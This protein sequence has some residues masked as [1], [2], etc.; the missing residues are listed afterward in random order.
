MSLW[1]QMPFLALVAL[2]DNKSWKRHLLSQA[3][4]CQLMGNYNEWLLEMRTV[5]RHKLYFIGFLRDGN[6]QVKNVYQATHWKSILS[7]KNSLKPVCFFFQPL[8]I[9]RLSSTTVMVN[10]TV[11]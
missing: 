5:F 8:G 6:K 3:T 10:E 1:E 2:A 9:C 4:S 7:E 11:F